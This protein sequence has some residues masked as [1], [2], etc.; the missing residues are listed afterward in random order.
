M[1]LTPPVVAALMACAPAFGAESPALASARAL[2]DAG[3]FPEAQ[4]AFARLEADE[5]ASGDVHYYLGQLAMERDD[6]DAAVR[7]L[8]KA[9]VLMPDG[10]RGHNA[11]GDAYG[12]SAQ[13]AGVLGKFSLARKCL[14][15]YQRAVALEPNNV[16][17]HE[18]LFG[19]CVGA[20]SIVGGGAD[21]AAEEAAI[22]GKLDAKRG[23]Q[24]MATLYT[25]GGK[26][27]LALG[28]LDEILKAAPDDYAALYQVGRV[29]ALSGQ[30]M[31]RGQA[32]LRRCLA[33]PVPEGAPPHCAAQW[34]IGTILERKGD[35]GGARAAY[36]AALRIDPKFTQASDSLRSLK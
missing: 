12:R 14:A 1:K 18:S 28:E 17:F 32:S 34:R 10:A 20:P 8:E 33:L 15:E 4:A 6:A 23:H 3:R 35:L 22:I 11:L 2:F 7:E 27:D 25:M 30:H 13:K 36:E 31:D 16:D 21:K 26:Y 19:Y 9:T 5:P 24:A 29:A